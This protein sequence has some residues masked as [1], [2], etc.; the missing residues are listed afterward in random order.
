M[1]NLLV[2]VTIFVP[3]LENP[4]AFLPAFDFPLYGHTI[5]P[6]KLFQVTPYS[7]PYL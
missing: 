2:E 3:P 1:Q 7:T 5:K 6:E 4:Y